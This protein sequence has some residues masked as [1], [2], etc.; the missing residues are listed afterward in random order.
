M[1]CSEL[2]SLAKGHFR[3]IDNPC[4]RY[5]RAVASRGPMGQLSNRLTTACSLALERGAGRR[6]SPVVWLKRGASAVTVIRHA[7]RGPNFS[8][9]IKE[10]AW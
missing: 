3:L 6:A 1:F 8:D 10:L 4:K 9:E 2:V 7:C 5:G